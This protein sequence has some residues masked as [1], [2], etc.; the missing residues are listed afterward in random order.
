MVHKRSTG[1]DGM[2]SGAKVAEWGGDSGVVREKGRMVSVATSSQEE[3]QD[4]KEA[5]LC[6]M[7][8]I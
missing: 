8:P 3:G 1:M 6:N 2:G 7:H 5:R 4:G